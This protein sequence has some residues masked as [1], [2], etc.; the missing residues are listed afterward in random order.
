MLNAIVHFSLRFRGIIIALAIL[1]LGYGGY[2]LLRAKFD[3][4]PEFAP[5]QVSIQTEA[6]GLSPEQVEVLVTQQLENVVNGTP[7]VSTLRSASIP[8]LSVI[9]VTFDP[10]SDIYRDRQLVAERIAEEAAQLPVGVE[11]PTMTPLT[12]STSVVLVAG[13]TSS[14]RS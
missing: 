9:T 5:P 1:L 11:P 7:G 6:P 14:K 12:S 4:F 2:T 10:A 13:L 8:G 3:V